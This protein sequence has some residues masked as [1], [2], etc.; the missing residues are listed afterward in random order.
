MHFGVQR[1]DAAIHHLGKTGV[2]GHVAHRETRFFQVAASAAGAED[3]DAGVDQRRQKSAS[4]VL[5][6]TL[7]KARLT[8][9]DCIAEFGLRIADCKT[10]SRVVSDPDY[11]ASPT[12]ASRMV[13]IASFPHA[14][15]EGRRF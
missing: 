6:L 10:A 11:S 15:N 13:T 2:V 1:L 14:G 9:G 8:G 3:F 7:T 4:P 5:S 12:P